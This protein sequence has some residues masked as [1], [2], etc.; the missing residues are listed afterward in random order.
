M[1]PSLRTLDLVR[2]DLAQP[3]FG[4][5]GRSRRWSPLYPT[6]LYSLTLFNVTFTREALKALAAAE[7]PSLHVLKLSS[8]LVS[9]HDVLDEEDYPWEVIGRAFSLQLTILVLKS[10]HFKLPLR[11]RPLLE[12]P[13]PQ[14]HSVYIEGTASEIASLYRLT[15]PRLETLEIQAPCCLTSSPLTLAEGTER[16]QNEAKIAQEIVNG[17]EAGSSLY[18]GLTSLRLSPTLALGAASVKEQLARHG[19][20]SPYVA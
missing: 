17:V 12:H 18:D 7:L 20:S 9:S 14:L 4:G 2:T 8:L 16:L 6:N 13:Y 5:L 3:F 1:G 15:A 19:T 11:L 10:G